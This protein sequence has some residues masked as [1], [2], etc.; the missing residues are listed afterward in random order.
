MVTVLV[1]AAGLAGCSDT[2]EPTTAAETVA[3]QGD[4][5]GWTDDE[6]A[7]ALVGLT[8]EEA[9]TVA[10]ENGYTTRVI[11]R[12]GEPQPATSDYREDRVNLAVEDGEVTAATLG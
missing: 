7:E 9:V 3:V 8:E 5:V 11:E 4:P 12:D 6:A 2:T 10:A 1:A